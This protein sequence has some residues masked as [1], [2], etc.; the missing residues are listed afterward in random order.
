[1]PPR[2]ASLTA[3]FTDS[4]ASMGAGY[5]IAAT[6]GATTCGG[7]LRAVP[8]TS[9][10]LPIGTTIP[11]RVRTITIPV[12]VAANAVTGARVNTIAQTV[13]QTTQGRT[14]SI[15]ATLTTSAALVVAKAFAPATVAALGPADR[16]A[17]HANG[18]PASPSGVHRQ[19]AC[20]PYD[21]G[22]AECRDQLWGVVTAVSGAVLFA[23]RRIASPA[24]HRARSR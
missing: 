8:V 18:A 7:A 4:L 15:T 24:P 10:S 3:V 17:D 20:G 16:H 22:N 6:A 14:I 5:T 1:M 19:P 2:A 12:Q 21:R 11:G 23:C 9:F 13:L